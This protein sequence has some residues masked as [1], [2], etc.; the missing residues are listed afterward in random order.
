MDPMCFIRLIFRL[1][2]HGVVTDNNTCLDGCISYDTVV[3]E[4]KC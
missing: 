4:Y 2:N 1:M 3:D